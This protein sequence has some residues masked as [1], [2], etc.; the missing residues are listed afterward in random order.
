[1]AT[2]PQDLAGF[3]PEDAAPFISAAAAVDINHHVHLDRPWT[4]RSPITVPPNTR[5][6][7]VSRDVSRLNRV[8]D[9]GDT[10]VCGDDVFGAGELVLENLWLRIDRNPSVDDTELVNRVTSGAHIH[11]RRAQHMR[12]RNCQLDGMTFG[13]HAQACTN[14]EIDVSTSGHWDLDRPGMQEGV[15]GIFLD[16]DLYD[17][18]LLPCKDIAIT[19]TDIIGGFGSNLRTVYYPNGQTRIHT[20]N[21]G[22]QHGVLVH[23]CESLKVAID[24]IGGQ[25][26]HGLSLIP[27]GVIS[28]VRVLGTFFDSS[29]LSSIYAER[30]SLDHYIGGLTL[31]DIE[32]NGQLIGDGLLEIGSYEGLPSVY[33]LAVRARAQSYR[34][35]PYRV[36]GAQHF[37]IS[38][39]ANGYN[40]QNIMGD[41]YQ[42]S[43]GLCLGSECRHG[44]VHGGAYGGGINEAGDAANYTK[45]GIWAGLADSTVKIATDTIAFGPYGIAGGGD[46]V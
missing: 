43:A 25:A 17:E 30:V 45:A 41:D 39:Q 20:V 23:A 27:H 1:M 24:N 2:R 19:G 11:A 15:A 31:A 40:A 28:N 14:T 6:E 46:V 32:G 33:G 36:W 18:E 4:V 9:Y 12:V 44:V 38:A 16:L 13:V 37:E 42:W 21:A 3:N 29:N 10:I 8:G 34:M 7:G 22:M 26:L 5:I 35:S